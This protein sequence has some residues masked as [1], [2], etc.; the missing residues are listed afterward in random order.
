MSAVLHD[1]VDVVL[2]AGGVG[3]A[4]AEPIKGAD[5]GHD[6]DETGQ[7]VSTEAG[8]DAYLAQLS[9]ADSVATCSLKR[10]SAGLGTSWIR[11]C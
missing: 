10:S 8:V 5:L 7:K 3:A 6:V 9:A 11:V 2:L 4:D 1:G